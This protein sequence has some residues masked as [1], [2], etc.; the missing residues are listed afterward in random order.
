MA[1]DSSLTL[2]ALDIGAR[3]HS[4]SADEAGRCSSG[5]TS[6]QDLKGQIQR[7]LRKGR[8][9]R[10]LMEATGVYYLD[11]ALLAHELGAEVMVV[12]PRA[13][14]NFARAMQQRSK[15]DAT[16]ASMLLEFLRRMPFQPWQ[17]PSQDRLALRAYGRYLTQLTEERTVAKNR[18][19]ALTSTQSSP[20]ALIVDLTEAIE[21][22]DR[23]IDGLR[24]EAVALIKADPQAHAAYQALLSVPGLGEVSAV[25]TLS[26]LLVLPQDMSGRACTSHAGLDV[27][28]HQ[29]G[30][31]VNHAPRISRHGNKYL[32][33][34]L[35]CPAMSASTHDPHARAFKERL[36]A[37]G[38]KPM[39][40]VVAIMRKLLTLI[41]AMV[42][43]PAPYD[44]ARLYSKP[45]GA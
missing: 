10:V 42:K 41:W 13:A 9:L 45:T 14:H 27:R 6:T 36:V 33:R 21:A 29:S 43:N 1:S 25:S 2:L 3:A 20:K 31:S 32:R 24:K 35:Y 34:A 8:P 40:A 7:L 12:N 44:G 39:Q 17:P 16:D 28:L 19:H 15:T 11:A 26:E 37:R 30:S 18:L 22:L 4:F 38:K 5:T 23:R